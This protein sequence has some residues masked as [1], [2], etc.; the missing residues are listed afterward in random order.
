MT[1]DE[2]EDAYLQLSKSIFKPKRVFGIRSKGAD[3]LRANGRFDS[4]AMETV[5]QDAI[6]GMGYAEDALLKDERDPG[7]KV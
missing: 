4:K 7:C 3:V 2:C 6:R 1:L 5:L